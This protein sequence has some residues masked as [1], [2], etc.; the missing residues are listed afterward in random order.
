MG[1]TARFAGRHVN[2]AFL[3]AEEAA[4]QAQEKIRRDAQAEAT[5]RER[6]WEQ[7]RARDRAEQEVQQESRKHLER[8]F[9]YLIE[10]QAD[11]DGCDFGNAGELYQCSKQ[12]AA[13]IAP[14]LREDLPLDFLSG[15]R[16]VEEL[17][18]KW[19]ASHCS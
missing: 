19:L 5:R 13:D 9:S 1:A 11:P 15:R 16:R 8:V 12:I 10:L 4:R 18:D 3:A 7:A 14:D 6:E 2:Q 17:V